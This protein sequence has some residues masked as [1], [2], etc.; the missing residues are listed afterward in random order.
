MKRG[1]KLYTSN[2][3]SVAT[4]KIPA[5]AMGNAIRKILNRNYRSGL[6]ELL[7]SNKSVK[8]AFLQVTADMVLK[9]SQALGK[10]QVLTPI[11]CLAD[12]KAF[13]WVSF[14]KELR[15]LCPLL[16]EMVIASVTSKHCR[17]AVVKRNKTGH[18]NLHPIVCS[19]LSQIAFTRNRKCSLFQQLNGIKLWLAGCKR[20]VNPLY[21]NDI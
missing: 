1:R 14:L 17:E 9:E 3:A 21:I 6:R 19:I 12:L 16:V 18:T 5:S 20:K 8:K 7:D 10:S 4:A 11:Q 2:S 15:Q 13:S